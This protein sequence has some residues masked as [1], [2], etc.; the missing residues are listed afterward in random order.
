MIDHVNRGLKRE[1]KNEKSTDIIF[2]LDDLQRPL[3]PNKAP[4]RLN[5]SGVSHALHVRDIQQSNKQAALVS[6]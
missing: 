6:N 3:A 1:S 2:T 5:S 4:T